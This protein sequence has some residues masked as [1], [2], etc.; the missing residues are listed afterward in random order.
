MT[1][2]VRAAMT[3]TRNAYIGF[4]STTAE[5]DAWDADLD[6]VRGA[7]IAHHEDLIATAAR[8]NVK[9]ICLGELCMGP[10]FALEER[11]L[12]RGLAEDAASGP[13]VTAMCAAA[14]QH[15]MVIVVPIYEHD[16][17][18]D[19][20]F[21][22]AVV[23]DAD[24][25]IVGKY[26]KTHIPYG[27]NERASFLENFYY[28]RSDGNLEGDPARCGS[29][30]YFPVF[31]TK[32]GKVGVA[33]CYDRH[34]V[35]A[36]TALAHGGA[37]VVFCPAVTFG[38]KSERMWQR[39]FDVDAARL[40]LFIGGSNRRG[41]EPPFD[42]EYFGQSHFTGPNQRPDPVASPEGLVVADL[43]FSELAGD[44]SGWDIARDARPDIY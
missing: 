11:E 30:P 35:G 25:S 9:A 16:A 15:D 29:D 37:E 6:A 7:N 22:T 20:R 41:V 14:R 4:P 36:M 23:I 2:I 1:R 38:A 17:V 33:I 28:E 34:F 8:L 32:V 42:V 19:T 39:E 31:T 13:S 40:N 18:T 43:N 10:Y 26:R 21:N 27:T 5:L 24:G 44:S 3:E 12:W